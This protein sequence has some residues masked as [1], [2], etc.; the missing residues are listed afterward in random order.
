MRI[1]NRCFWAAVVLAACGILSSVS[2]GND[3]DEL[4]VKKLSIIDSQGRDRIV[5][6]VNISADKAEDSQIRFVRPGMRDDDMI[7][8]D[9]ANRTAIN[10]QRDLNDKKLNC[11]IIGE[12]EG[13]GHHPDVGIYSEQKQQL[14]S[15]YDLF[16][17]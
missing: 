14:L 6:A 9:S 10:L 5:L 17:K 12:T 1:S 3:S 2:H 4:R 13:F 7:L 15:L 11:L 16:Q 8:S